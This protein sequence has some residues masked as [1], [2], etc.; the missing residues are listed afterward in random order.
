MS[1]VR[2]LLSERFK[3]TVHREEKEFPIYALTLA[4]N[5]PKLTEAA[6]ETSP[7]GSPP[8]VFVLSPDGARLA[9]RNATMA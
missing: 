1:M 7:E 5:G 9:A 3:L 6:A 2:Q 8:L 4:K